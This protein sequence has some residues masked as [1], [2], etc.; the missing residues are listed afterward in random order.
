MLLA[1]ASV[2]LAA[3]RNSGET[4]DGGVRAVAA[5]QVEA[6]GVTALAISASFAGFPL[7]RSF[8]SECWFLFAAGPQI[9]EE[10]GGRPRRRASR[11]WTTVD[12]VIL[13]GQRIFRSST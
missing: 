8:R 3:F 4:E 9:A 7:W 13:S 10:V 1:E 2:L 11:E 5:G 12:L 6:E